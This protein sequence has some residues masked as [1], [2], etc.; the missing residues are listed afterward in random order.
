[1]NCVRIGR[2]YF[3]VCLALFSIV[4]LACE[5]EQHIKIVN[6]ADRSLG[7]DLTVPARTEA[8]IRLKKIK[9]LNMMDMW[10]KA[11]LYDLNAHNRV[12]E[13]L[14][15]G[16][17]QNALEII[18]RELDLSIYAY[19]YIRTAFQ[20]HIIKGDAAA[21]RNLIQELIKQGLDVN[22]VWGWLS[23]VMDLQQ[24][25]DIFIKNGANINHVIE[26]SKGKFTAPVFMSLGITITHEGIYASPVNG[27]INGLLGVLIK[28]GVDINKVLV[29]DE[30]S[31]ESWTP[32]LLAIYQY[33]NQ[34]NIRPIE[35]LLEA[36]A[37]VN[38]KANPRPFDKNIY[39][40][41][42]QTPLTLALNLGLT[43]VVKLLLEHG[44]TL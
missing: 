15:K 11:M 20:N 29:V 42:A 3:V 22:A 40:R 5:R 13:Y 17:I 10:Q 1:M 41:E 31:K 4:S 44:A 21:I 6:D 43:E 24:Y 2:Q 16:E 30:S 32:L 37:D 34:A 27:N 35:L 8:L 36:G 38:Q 19:I 14:K 28:A 39:L 23:E 9:D 25:L 12:M 7:V 33:N 18:K 26:V